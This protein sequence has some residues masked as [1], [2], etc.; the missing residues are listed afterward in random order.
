MQV[1]FATTNDSQVSAEMTQQ[2]NIKKMK[3]TRM[4][5]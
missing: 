1:I 4:T 3:K 2:E 5:S